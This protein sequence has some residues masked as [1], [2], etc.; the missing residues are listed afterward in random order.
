MTQHRVLHQLLS[1]AARDLCSSGRLPGPDQLLTNAVGI[2]V[3]WHWAVQATARPKT[4]IHIYSAAYT[5]ER[6]DH[7][8]GV[9]DIL[10]RSRPCIHKHQFLTDIYIERWKSKMRMSE[11]LLVAEVEAW[12]GHNVDFA[13]EGRL[14][15]DYLCDFVKLLYIL[16]PKRLFIACT[17]AQRLNDL[18]ALLSRA[19]RESPISN[20]EHTQTE[21]GVILLPAGVTQTDNIRIGVLGK[22]NKL[23]FSTVSLDMR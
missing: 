11:P 12:P 23:T 15:S 7:W 8:K 20:C 6:S 13:Y 17:R 5:R 19:V 4:N 21:L 22:G 9:E 2:H 14:R 16:A 18:Q 3:A 1:T 10:N